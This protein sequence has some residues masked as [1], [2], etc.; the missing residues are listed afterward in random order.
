[1]STSTRSSTRG[2]LLTVNWVGHFN[3]IKLVAYIN[4]KQKM[5]AVSLSFASVNTLSLYH[6][7]LSRSDNVAYHSVYLNSNLPES[8]WVLISW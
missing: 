4:S 1:M 8:Q 5:R 2:T 3:E 6:L 7:V